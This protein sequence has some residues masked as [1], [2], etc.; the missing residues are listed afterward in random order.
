MALVVG[1]ALLVVVAVIAGGWLAAGLYSSELQ[2]RA[3]HP[4]PGD[5]VADRLDML[6]RAEL[7]NPSVELD[8]RAGQILLVAGETERS[9]RTLRDVVRR[10]PDNRFA[11]AGLV[12]ALQESDPGAARRALSELRRLVPP[13][14][15]DES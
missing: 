10:E 15:D 9:V 5:S 3:E 14:E 2:E 7:L 11:W 13:V 12:Q 8:L 6:D 4:D 1:R